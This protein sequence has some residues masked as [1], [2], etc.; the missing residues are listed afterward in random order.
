MLLLSKTINHW[1]PDLYERLRE[2][3]DFRERPIYDM[4]AILMGGLAIFLLK[5]GSRKALDDDRKTE[6]FSANFKKIFK[7]PLP[8]CD[9]IDGILRILSIDELEKLKNELVSQ[10]ISKKVFD[11]FR[12]LGKYI[13][14]AIDGTGLGSE[15]EK[16]YENCPYKEY[17]NKETGE[18]K[19]VYFPFVLE[20]KIVCGN[21]FSISIQTEWLLDE[22]AEYNKH[23][24]EQNAFVRLAEKLKKIYPRLC[25]CLAVDG[26]YPNKTFFKLCKDYGWKYIVTLKDNSLKTVQL[27]IKRTIKRQEKCEFND[28]S[29]KTISCYRWINGIDYNGF[30]VQWIECI[31]TTKHKAKGTEEIHKFVHLTNLQITDD[32]YLEISSGGRLRWKI[33]NEGFNIQKNNGYALKHK[34]SRVNFRARQNYY[35]LLQI[36]HM[37]NQLFERCEKFLTLKGHFAVKHVW[38]MLIAFLYFGHIEQLLLNTV[39]KHRTQFKYE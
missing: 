11:K 13:V 26:L 16:P 30:E 22:G 34:Y 31:E 1:F 29:K 32:N 37:I 20:A 35:Q 19:V 33:E 10:L 25:I 24:C 28:T 39:L 23:D 2:I 15:K 18:V 17:T 3:E 12:L 7:V 6:K 8:H 5:E 36:A 14:I 21:G 9:T 38:K 4:T 27:K